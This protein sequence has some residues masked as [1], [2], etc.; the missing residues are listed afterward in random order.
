MKNT[1]RKLT[2]SFK[3]KVAL[4]SIQG[5][6][7]LAQLSSEHKVNSNQ[8]SKWKKQLLENAQS[9]FDK[10][11]CNIKTEEKISSPLYEEIGR[12]KMEVEWLKKKL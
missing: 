6:K 9:I 12:L 3:T 5:I 10:K 11:N 1:R 7:T 2:S 8:I 4:D